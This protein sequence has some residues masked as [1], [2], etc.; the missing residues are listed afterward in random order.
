MNLITQFD[1][2]SRSC[3]PYQQR[4]GQPLALV[5]AVGVRNACHRQQVTDLP[6]GEAVVG[7]GE[8]AGNCGDCCGGPGGVLVED[9]VD[10]QACG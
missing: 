10:G 1:A 7:G 9:E 4:T 2:W 3:L 5:R 6:A 8:H